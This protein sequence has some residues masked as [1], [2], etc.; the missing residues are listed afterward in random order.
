MGHAQFPPQMASMSHQLPAQRTPHTCVHLVIKT[1]TICMKK[2]H[3]STGE[4]RHCV[5]MVTCRWKYEFLLPLASP[6]S[7]LKTAN[8]TLGLPWAQWQRTRLPMRETRVPSL[9]REDPLEEGM[10]THS[11][12]LA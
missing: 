4:H 12:V 11:S 2:W 8:V 9:G 1:K 6:H 10:A 3:I 7:G 5:R